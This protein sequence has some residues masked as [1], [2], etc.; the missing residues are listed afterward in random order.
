MLSHFGV[1]VRSEGVT[2]SVA[3]GSVLRG[4]EVNVPADISSAAFFMVAAALVPESELRLPGVCISP[5]REG[6]LQALTRMG[7]ALTVE[8]SRLLSGENVADL[9][10]R[11]AGRLR[12]TE[13]SDPGLIPSLIDEIPILA[14]AAAAAEGDTVIG[15]AS[16]LRVKETDRIGVLAAELRKIGVRIDERPDGMVIHGGP[17][18]GGAADS[19]GDHRL[20]MSLAVAGLASETGVTVENIECVNTSFPGFWEFLDEVAK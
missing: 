19:H 9:T 10:V 20:A 7:A 14:V 15:N 16:E 8:N 18:H 4:R 12:G 2:V 5:G 17:I 3:G 11:G 13:I 1:P 6:V